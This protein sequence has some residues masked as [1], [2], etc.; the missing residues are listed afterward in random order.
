[1]RRRFGM[2]AALVV[3][4]LVL[5]GVGSAGAVT[6]PPWV[7]HVQR[8]PG[9]ISGGVRAYLDAGTVG[10][11]PGLRAAPFAA[12]LA[13]PLD[14]LKVNSL[15]SSPPVPQNETQVVYNPNNPMIAV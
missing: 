5:A 2:S 8:Y 4:W 9:G 13:S 14:N 12:G 15:D 11:S 3:G 6:P 10:R 7:Q 1:M